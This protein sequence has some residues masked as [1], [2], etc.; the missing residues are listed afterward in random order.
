MEQQRLR[1]TVKEKL[2][3]T[4]AQKQALEAVLWRCRDLYTAASE[5][6]IT[7]WQRRRVSLSRYEQ[8]AELKDMRAEAPE[9]AALHSPRLQDVL[10]RLDKTSQAFFRRIQRGAQAGFPRFKGRNRFHSVTLKE[11]GAGARVDTG[12]LVL[13]TMGRIS[14]HWSRPIA[15]T[16]KTLT[17]SKEADGWYVAIS[18]ADVPAHLVPAT[19][20][21]T[22]ID[23]G[24][25]SFATLA[26]G[27]PSFT[28]RYSRKAA[29][30]LRRCQRRVARR[31]AR[32][33]NGSH[34]R[35]KAVALLATAHQ[36]LAGQR[37]DFHDTAAHTL[38]Q[39]Y[40]VLY[41]VLSSADLRVAY[42]V[43]NHHLAKSSS[44]AGWRALLAILAFTAAT[45]GTAG[46]RVQTVNPAVTS[47]ACSG[48]G[49]L[50]QKG[51]SLRW[52][53]CGMRARTGAPACSAI[54]PRRSTSGG[55]GTSNGGRDTAF[56]RERSPVGPAS[57][58][59]PRG[60]SP[61]GVS[62]LLHGMDKQDHLRGEL[63]EK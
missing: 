26:N 24:V 38:V 40:A 27:Q 52:H 32:R 11:D 25:E 39:A 10:A 62:V 54:T 51:L 12:F 42:R 18:C 44:D 22:G 20:H 57:P 41:A 60:F 29:A 36:H 61:G 30:D 63:P 55:W 21:E 9:Y 31:V 2:R 6:R 50:V 46:K 14:V 5:Q 47:Q 58:E 48:C 45:A 1:T 8:E 53:A 23:L 37:R 15:G 16:P 43:T 49:V 59:H 3:P 34:R 17:V 7:A 28:P 13:S 56:R 4:P 19:R 35:R 33:K